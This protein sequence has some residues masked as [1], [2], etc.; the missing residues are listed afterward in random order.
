MKDSNV[1]ILGDFNLN[2]HMKY[3]QDYSHKAYFDEQIQKA[4]QIWLAQS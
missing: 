1:I 4:N 3:S 2:E